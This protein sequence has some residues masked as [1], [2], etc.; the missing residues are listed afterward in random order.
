MRA[1]FCLHPLHGFE[2]SAVR[3]EAQHLYGVDTYDD[4]CPR[5][6][7][8]PRFRVVCADTGCRDIA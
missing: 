4:A 5:G 6:R 1:R 8:G 3:E 7:A 2:R